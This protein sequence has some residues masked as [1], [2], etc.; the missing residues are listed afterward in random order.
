MISNIRDQLARDE[1]RRLQPYQDDEGWWTI[2]I[3]HNLGT[4]DWNE[5][6]PHFQ[7]GITDE[8]CDTLFNADLAHAC[9]L[10]DVYVPWWD[11]L[12]GQTGARSGV[13]INMAFNMGPAKLATFHT[14]LRLMKAR[15]W[16]GAADDLRNHTLVYKQ[17]PVRYE[18]L[19]RQIETGEWQ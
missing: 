14:F 19:A 5:L 10:L 9:H 4:K 2:G 18:R 16:N 13:L 15:D 8:E 17:L 3:G 1:G 6:P 7:D 12:D 11:Q